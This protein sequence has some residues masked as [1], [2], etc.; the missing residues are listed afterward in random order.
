MN[1]NSF[2]PLAEAGQLIVWLSHYALKLPIHDPVCGISADEITGTL[3][4][5]LVIF[6]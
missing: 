5:S 4:A 3:A 6:G 2:F 1:T